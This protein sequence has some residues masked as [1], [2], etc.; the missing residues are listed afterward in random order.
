ML[1]QFVSDFFSSELISRMHSKTVAITDIWK[2]KIQP[3]PK[4]LSNILYTQLTFWP[5]LVLCQFKEQEGAL[6]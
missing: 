5:E 2:G 6:G 3:F 1:Q 4:E